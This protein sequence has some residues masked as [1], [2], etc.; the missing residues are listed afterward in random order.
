MLDAGQPT[1]RPDYYVRYRPALDDV[2]NEPSVQLPFHDTRI[3]LVD[4][5]DSGFLGGM[6]KFWD[7]VTVPF[8]FTTKNNTR[9]QCAWVL[10]IAG[11]AW[12]DASL[13]YAAQRA[14]KRKPA[15]M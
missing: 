5:Y 4:H 1:E 8:G 15:Q 12:G 9:V 2:L 14:K 13:F 7:D 10:V 11:C 3:Y 6:Q